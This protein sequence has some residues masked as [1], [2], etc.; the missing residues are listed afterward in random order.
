MLS[1]RKSDTL[2]VIVHEIHGVNQHMRYLTNL[3]D[4]LGM[5]VICPNL[6]PPG[7]Q[8]GESEEEEY[9]SFFKHVGFEKAAAQIKGTVAEN[10]GRY[11][12][13]YVVGFSVGATAAWLCSDYEGVSGILCFYG[14]RI[15]DYVEVNPISPAL[16]F[17]SNKEKSFDVH[18]LITQLDKKGNEYIE[19]HLFDAN[20]GFANPYSK[21]FCQKAFDESFSILK[22][23]ITTPAEAVEQ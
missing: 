14:S 23:F 17:F 12:N 8:L 5:D 15:R 21:T 2:V 11:K 16:L 9:K 6:Y 20:H 3:I 19:I 18:P 22:E 7:M 13:I 1:C 4:H 10:R